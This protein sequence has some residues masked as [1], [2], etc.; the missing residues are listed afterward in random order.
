MSKESKTF[1]AAITR[2]EEIVK[3]SVPKGTAELNLKALH[4]GIALVSK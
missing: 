4:A 2:L 1:E 3:I